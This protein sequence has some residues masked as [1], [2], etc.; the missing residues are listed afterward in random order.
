M[1]IH[2]TA[3]IH[4]TAE[5]EA[6]ADIGPYCIIGAEVHLGP[7]TRLKANKYLEGPT[8]VGEDNVF[9]PYS[10]TGVAS[11]DLTYHAQAPSAR[12]RASWPITTSKALPGSARITSS[13]P[14]APRAW[15]RRTS[16]TRASAPRPASATATASANSSPSIAAPRAADW[17][18]L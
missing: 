5:I 12:A 6:S 14:T 8:W 15:P 16:N 10:T 3:I 9:F 13:S 18:P 2:P 17:S 4:P 7:R 11:Q 1:P